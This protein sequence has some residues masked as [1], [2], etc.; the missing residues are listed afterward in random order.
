MITPA[1]RTKTIETIISASQKLD[2]LEKKL[3]EV[4]N[5]FEDVKL[6]LAQAFEKIGADIPKTA[7]IYVVK[8]DMF[9]FKKLISILKGTNQK[10][11]VVIRNSKI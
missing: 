6:L 10:T 9:K 8:N 1:E 2:G 3:L 11:A 5:Q 7:K 4:I